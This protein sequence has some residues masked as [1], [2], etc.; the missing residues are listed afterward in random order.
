[1]EEIYKVKETDLIG[2]IEGFPIEVVQMMMVRQ[3]EHR[4]ESS[5]SAFQRDRCSGYYG[6]VWADTDEGSDFWSAVIDYRDFTVFFERY[7]GSR[8]L[9][10]LKKT[11]AIKANR[12]KWTRQQ[13]WV[14]ERLPVIDGATL[15]QRIEAVGS[16][17]YSGRYI[18][19]GF[20]M[21]VLADEVER[22]LSLFGKPMPDDS[23]MIQKIMALSYA[24][25]NELQNIRKMLSAFYDGN[26]I[27]AIGIYTG[28]CGVKESKRYVKNWLKKN[29][30]IWRH[31]LSSITFYG[32]NNSIRVST[33]RAARHITSSY[34]KDD[35]GF[36]KFNDRVIIGDMSYLIQ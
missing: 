1:M 12:I 15:K 35:D 26:G 11:K 23:D 9:V 32:A 4:G 22:A 25:Q 24:V 30:W 14:I 5:I 19:S 27:D 6:F 16:L 33:P 10:E 17:Y 29:A 36:Y 31:M 20:D 21:P 8:P 28:I 2:E 7:P 3:Y 13:L 34:K 18:T